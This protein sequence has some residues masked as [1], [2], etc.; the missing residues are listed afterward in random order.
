MFGETEMNIDGSKEVPLMGPEE[1]ATFL[2]S[3][4]KMKY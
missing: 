4:E 2:D 1:F 3:C